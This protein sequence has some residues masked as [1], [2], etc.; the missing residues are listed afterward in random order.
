M[1]LYTENQLRNAIQHATF[2]EN[3]M[4]ESIILD[5]LTPIELPTIDHIVA[6]SKENPDDPDIGNQ[7]RIGF[8]AGA[9]WMLDKIQK[10]KK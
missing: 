9:K 2:S 6:K 5:S 10:H 1:K 3:I 8:I 4:I 7:E